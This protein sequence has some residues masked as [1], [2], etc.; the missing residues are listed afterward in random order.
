MHKIVDVAVEHQEFA[1]SAKWNTNKY[2]FNEFDLD[3][4]EVQVEE[5]EA[6]KIGVIP[7]Q[8]GFIT[9]LTS[10]FIADQFSKTVILPT[11]N[12][13]FHSIGREA[14]CDLVY[15]EA[16][17][18]YVVFSIKPKPSCQYHTMLRK[19]SDS[20][21]GIFY[22][23]I[24]VDKAST[25]NG[26]YKHENFKLIA[27]PYG[28]LDVARFSDTSDE[29]TSRKV[30]T[31]P[32]KDRLGKKDDFRTLQDLSI[33]TRF[34]VTS[35]GDNIEQLEL[36]NKLRNS[37]ASLKSGGIVINEKTGLVCGHNFNGIL[38]KLNGPHGYKNGT[39][40][41]FKAIRFHDPDITRPTFLIINHKPKKIYA[42][43]GELC[44]F[45]DGKFKFKAK[46][47]EK[48][49]CYEALQLFGYVPCS[50]A[51]PETST[52]TAKSGEP[53]ERIYEITAVENTNLPGQTVLM[54]GEFVRDVTVRDSNEF[55]NR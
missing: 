42:E 46:F 43:M 54:H 14:Q 30:Y 6:V 21:E 39:A 12:K 49:G 34:E 53:I 29:G 20:I 11:H 15:N 32:I 10:I 8:K 35:S 36:I 7:D 38:F 52:L 24:N 25:V 51:P 23:D 48:L 26:F 44:S 5:P 37:K 13:K 22:V 33:I 2:Q 55:Y 41:I 9:G 16:L 18:S 45:S 31:V 47:N 3:D 4:D 17:K 27:D 28:F 50:V 1:S 40:I 19:K